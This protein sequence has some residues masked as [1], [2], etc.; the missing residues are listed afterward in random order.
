MWSQDRNAIGCSPSEHREKEGRALAS[1]SGPEE[2]W[3]CDTV[4][5]TW[6][7][8][9]FPCKKSRS[10]LAARCGACIILRRG[11]YC[12]GVAGREPHAGTGSDFSWTRNGAA[13]L[14][15]VGLPLPGWS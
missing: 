11:L 7:I 1:S 12:N 8:V 10:F 4:H 3:F 13:L 6:M 2:P 9:E 15:A 14:G 5:H